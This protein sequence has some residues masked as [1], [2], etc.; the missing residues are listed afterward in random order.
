MSGYFVF[1]PTHLTAKLRWVGLEADMALG[2]ELKRRAKA[3]VAP[4]VFLS[5]VGYFGW[6]ATQGDHGLVAYTQRQQLL[7][8]AQGDLANAR[9]ELADWQRRVAALQSDHLD[10][11]ILDQRARAMLNLSD[12]GDIIV[13]YPDKD[14]LY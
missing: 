13:P 5:L 14:R 4:L 6:N 12:P 2:R 10:A 11:D 3:A 9:A 8:R 1:S 7:K